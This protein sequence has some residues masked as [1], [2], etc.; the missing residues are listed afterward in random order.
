[1]KDS[2]VHCF[3]SAN[4]LPMKI[5]RNLN[6]V[7]SITND[8]MI[9]PFH[10]Q[11]NP[12]NECTFV[13]DNSC[14]FC[15]CENRP[16]KAVFPVTDLAYLVDML[17]DLGCESMTVTGGG[18]PLKYSAVTDLAWML[19]LAG[20]DMG[21]VTNGVLLAS[22]EPILFEM[23]TWIRISSSDELYK[24]TGTVNWVNNIRKVVLN[25]P[26]V[27]WAF[28]HVMLNIPNHD[29]RFTIL[30]L[31]N[32][33]NFTHIRFVNDLLNLPKTYDSMGALSRFFK[34]KGI[35]DSRVIY[36]SRQNYVGGAK[37]CFISLL[38]P[39]ISAEGKLYPC[40]GVQY[41]LKD[42]SRSY[43]SKMCMGH[44]TDLPELIEKQKFFDGSDCVKC[45]Y[46]NY[47]DL[48]GWLL[49]EYAHERFI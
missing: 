14:S 7:S 16:K 42:P 29:F 1:M 44:W 10:A 26:N 47:N 21:L 4:S 48:L 2:L 46:N 30:D 17:K 43:E 20:I 13:G 33:L 8:K 27:D 31:A 6:L 36:Q 23:A 9:L 35:D 19:R 39:V 25:H 38:K 15:S 24:H 28:S 49:G 37:K 11:F 12:T 41:A 22:V 32:K 3:S 5:F 40:C 45:Y 34:D 18:D